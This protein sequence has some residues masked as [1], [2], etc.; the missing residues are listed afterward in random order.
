M[1]QQRGHQR[2]E[3]ARVTG[4]RKAFRRESHQ[5]FPKGNAAPIFPYPFHKP[6]HTT[7]VKGHQWTVCL[8]DQRFSSLANTQQ[9]CQENKR[10]NQAGNQI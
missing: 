6:I 7:A 4:K 5:H 10:E 3:C 9:W 2:S 8:T 1:Q